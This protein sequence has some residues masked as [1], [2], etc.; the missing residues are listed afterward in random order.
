ML[1]LQQG[2]FVSVLDLTLWT[3]LSC[4]NNNTVDP[5][6][7]SDS[8]CRIIGFANATG[9]LPLSS[10]LFKLPTQTVMVVSEGFANATGYLP[11]ASSFFKLPTQTVMVVS[12]GSERSE[13]SEESE[14][15]EARLEVLCTECSA[16]C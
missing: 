9:Y 16:E 4:R 3:S 10:S 15:S 5:A 1:K 14:E 6:T 12:E 8:S 13:V 7:S 11:L 2:L